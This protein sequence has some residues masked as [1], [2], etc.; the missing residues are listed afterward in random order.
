M[1]NREIHASFGGGISGSIQIEYEE[2]CT[3]D[4][5]NNSEKIRVIS[6]TLLSY[7]PRK[8]VHLYIFKWLP[9]GPSDNHTN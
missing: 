4:F 8:L 5:V 2:G 9:V 1:A 3:K 7:D 6:F